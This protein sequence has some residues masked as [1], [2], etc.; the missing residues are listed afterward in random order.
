MTKIYTFGPGDGFEWVLLH[1][2]EDRQK[3]LELGEQRIADGFEPLRA[4]RILEDEG[5]TFHEA[6][7]PW[8]SGHHLVMRD[9]VREEKMEAAVRSRIDELRAA[10]DIEVLI[11]IEPPRSGG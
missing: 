10:A 8:M 5:E 1:E 2:H 11:A 7:M 6:D 3:L 9:H 4:Y